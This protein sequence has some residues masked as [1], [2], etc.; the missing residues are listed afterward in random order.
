M[1]ITEHHIEQAILEYL[2]A[3]GW[4]SIKL[5]DQVRQGSSPGKFMF[6][7]VADIVAMHDGETVWFEVKKPG[8]KQSKYQI[9]FQE[10]VKA[11][12]CRYTVVYSVLDVRTYIR[13]EFG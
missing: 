3:L 5:K 4:Y 11:S 8:G 7:G 10:A 12:G 9:A 6:R 13:K 1:K 2:T